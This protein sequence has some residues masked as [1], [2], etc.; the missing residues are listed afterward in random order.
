MAA[1]ALTC[2]ADG[3]STTLPDWH[4]MWPRPIFTS[5]LTRAPEGP[6][7]TMWHLIFSIRETMRYLAEFPLGEMKELKPAEVATMLTQLPP[8]SAFVRCNETVGV[9]DTHE[10]PR[11]LAGDELNRRFTFV[12][13]QTRAKYCRARDVVEKTLLTHNAQPGPQTEAGMSYKPHLPAN[14]IALPTPQLPADILDEA[15]DDGGEG[16]TLIV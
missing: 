3:C 12:R 11:K 16:D 1:P 7:E 5:A 9:M 6:V 15:S 14:G 8:R 2:C 10:V 4:L 13:D